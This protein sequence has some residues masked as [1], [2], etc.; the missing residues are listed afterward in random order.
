MYMQSHIAKGIRGS[1]PEYSK[2][3]DFLKPLKHSL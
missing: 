3:K 1:V 2:A